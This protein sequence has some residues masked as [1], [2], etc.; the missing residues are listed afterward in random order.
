MGVNINDNGH[1]SIVEAGS[2]SV[3]PDLMPCGLPVYNGASNG[4]AG[5]TEPWSLVSNCTH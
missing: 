2:H 1:V 5:V 3:K 4:G